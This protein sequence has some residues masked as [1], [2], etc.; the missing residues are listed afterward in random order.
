MNLNRYVVCCLLLLRSVMLQAQIDSAQ[1]NS[2]TITA[3]RFELFNAGTH[4]QL[5]DSAAAASF[6]TQTL[7]ELLA[8]QSQVFIKTYGQG[9]LATASFRGSAA[10]HTA[11]VWKGFN[12]QNPMYGQVDFSLIP[13]EFVDQVAVQYG[14]NGALYGSG[15][16]GGS[17]QLLSHNRFGEGLRARAG[18]QVG[19]F[20]LQRWNVGASYSNKH[21]IIRTRYFQLNADN[22]F[23]FKNTFLPDQPMVSQTNASVDLK[24]LLHEQVWRWKG[25]QE[26]SIN[27]WYQQSNKQIPPSMSVAITNAYQKDDALRL[28]A[29]WKKLHRNMVWM[30]RSAWFDEQVDYRNP[31]TLLNGLSESTTSITEAE[32]RWILPRSQQLNLGVNHTWIK[33]YADGY[34]GTFNQH[35]TALFA[36]YRIAY[37]KFT[38]SASIREEYI[39]SGL[40]PL[41]PAAGLTYK[42]TDHVSVNMSAAGS[43]RL[44]TFNEQ[45]WISAQG[46]TIQP[47]IG[48]NAEAGV[49]YKKEKGRWSLQSD[50]TVFNRQVRNWIVWQPS[51][52]DWAPRNLRAVW[53]RGLEYKLSSAYRIGKVRLAHTSMANYI[54]STPESSFLKGDIAL[55]KQ[56]IYV[57]RLTHQHQFFVYYQKWQFGYLHNYVGMRFITTDHSD[58]LHDYQTATFIAGQQFTIQKIAITLRVQ[59]NNL[60]NQSYQAVA[61]R[62]MPGRNFLLSTQFTF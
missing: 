46:S 44:P 16:V 27:G 26:L 58:W 5:L 29:E 11:V 37:K 13:L 51:F 10:E 33:A 57:P 15:A 25:N 12:L 45:F 1:L 55:G 24:G 14:G 4:T 2:V 28:T 8:A 18:Y 34:R 50:M 35:R 60:W 17:I 42:W 61:D 53:T 9:S 32:V 30:V 38:M 59:V 41:M 49:S 31:L 56:L 22:N 54:L 20:G 7:A 52:I 19:S 6:Q 48:W 23:T 21:W 36:S 62:P 40:T 3:S 43:Y 39:P 47:E